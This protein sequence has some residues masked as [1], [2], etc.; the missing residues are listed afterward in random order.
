MQIDRLYGWQSNPHADIVN[1]IKK[2]KANTKVEFDERVRETTTQF[3]EQVRK[4]SFHCEI[5]N[6]Q[7]SKTGMKPD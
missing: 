3:A 6:T 1:T 5:V 4:I 7:C 2:Q